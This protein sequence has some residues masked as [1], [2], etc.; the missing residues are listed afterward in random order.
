MS[1]PFDNG[2]FFWD[3]LALDKLTEQE[4]LTLLAE[5]A[6]ASPGVWTGPL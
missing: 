1:V 5:P 2:D 4:L 3:R 6:E